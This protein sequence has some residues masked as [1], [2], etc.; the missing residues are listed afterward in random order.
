MTGAPLS[1]FTVSATPLTC[2]SSRSVTVCPTLT[3]MAGCLRGLKPGQLRGRVVRAHRQHRHA[4][5]SVLV[6]D[7][8]ALDAGRGLDHGDG[9][10]GQH[11]AGL[12]DD[13]PFDGSRRSSVRPPARRCRSRTPRRSGRE[14]CAGRTTWR[15][16]WT[17]GAEERRDR[18]LCRLKT[19]RATSKGVNG[20]EARRRVG[21]RAV[22][23]GAVVPAGLKASTTLVV[24]TFRSARERQDYPPAP[25][26]TAVARS[27]RV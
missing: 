11:R 21:V 12:I 24:P 16:P 3:W 19:V 5:Q 27:M 18:D 4:E 6:G 25:V 1:T 2:I 20:G 13:D 26:G 7:R 14:R 22:R 23:E 9:H 17:G 10:A 8:P 15:P